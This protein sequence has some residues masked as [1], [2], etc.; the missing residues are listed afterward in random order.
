MHK[1]NLL[2]KNIVKSLSNVGIVYPGLIPQWGVRHL[3]R[4]IPQ[5]TMNNG[6]KMPMIGLGTWGATDDFA[7]IESLGLGENRE[8]GIEPNEMVEI[9]KKAIDCGYRHFDTA[10]MY[11]NEK[12]IGEAI[13][14][15]IKDDTVTRNELFISSKLWHTYANPERVILGCKRSLENLGLD[16]IDL[17]LI[18]SPLAAQANDDTLYPKTKDGKP[19]YANVHYVCTW[20]AM[21]DLQKEG[22]CKSIGISN[23]NLK[24]VKCI[25]EYG[26]IVPQ[27]HQIEHHPY[28]TQRALIGFCKAHNIAITAYAPLGS[29]NRPWAFK[30]TP[31]ALL[32]D[33]KASKH[34]LTNW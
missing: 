16:Y 27:N 33:G 17:Y 1:I 18:H 29:P 23:F 22:L 8:K 32:S 25:L 13:Q 5:I 26:T 15:K 20:R 24:Q 3:S 21:E 9:T 28:L 12:Q 14:Q 31:K 10:L 11:G 19:A 30:D 34:I 7:E 6:C 4:K 2:A